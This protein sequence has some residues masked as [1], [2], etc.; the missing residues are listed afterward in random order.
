MT[1]RL[2][3]TIGLTLLAFQFAAIIYAR[4]VDSRYF[5][6]APYDMQTD[7][8]ISARVNG[9]DL[10]GNEIVKRYRRGAKGTDNRSFQ[11]I[12]DIVAGAEQRYHP[13]DH[14]DITIT[15]SINGG[16]KQQWHYR[17]P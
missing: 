17:Q 2:R 15:Y 3:W 4:Y 9:R 8:A 13:Q 5:C 6:W 1:R 14:S 16:P 10:S 7:Y 12:I 11:H